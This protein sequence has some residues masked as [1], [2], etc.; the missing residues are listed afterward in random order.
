MVFKRDRNPTVGYTGTELELDTFGKF[1]ATADFKAALKE[2]KR[3]GDY[4]PYEKMLRLIREYDPVDPTNP[5]K[6][7]AKELRMA[8]I[9]ELGL[10]DEEWD[11]I[12]YHSAVGTILDKMHGVDAFIE[13]VDPKSDTVVVTVTMDITKNPNKDTYK[14]D[15]IIN[16]EI[17][18][19]EDDNFL[20]QVEAWSKEVAEKM[21]G[22]IEDWKAKPKTPSGGGGR[23]R[24]VV[25]P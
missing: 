8:V 24:R 22:A 6:E 1:K 18:E 20:D 5:D 21:R 15:V 19:P 10:D 16:E 25:I 17:A 12:K 14:A 13:Y 11:N 3:E 2:V 9:E 4:A 7:F 23:R